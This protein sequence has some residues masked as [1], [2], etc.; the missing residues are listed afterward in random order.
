MIGVAITG[1]T[2]KPL[3]SVES[4]FQPRY[5]NDDI[6]ENGVLGSGCSRFPLIEA[7]RRTTRIAI[8]PW[9]ALQVDCKLV[10]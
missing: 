3:M 7:I 6:D 1:A 10:V 2:V 8:V 5:G 9:W 4:Y